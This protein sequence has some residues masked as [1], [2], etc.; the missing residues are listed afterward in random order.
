MS[1]IIHTLKTRYVL[2]DAYTSTQNKITASTQ[3]FSQAQGKGTAALQLF[4]GNISQAGQAMGM[5]APQAMALQ[6]AV[7]FVTKAIEVAIKTA[8][9][10]TIAFG[11]FSLYASHQAADFEAL[12][13]GIKAYTHDAKE[14]ADAQ[15]KFIEVAKLPGLGIKES[16]AGAAQLMSVGFDPTLAARTMTEFGN[17]LALVGKG[18][19]DLDGVI[20]ALTQIVSK[21]KVSAEEILQIAE[22]VPQIRELMARAFGTAN[23]ETLQQMNISVEEFI[24]K[25]VDMAEKTIPRM[26][27]GMK[28]SWE[29]MTDSIDKGIIV[30]G[31]A[32]NQY[33]GPGLDFLGDWL[34]MVAESGQLQTFVDGLMEAVG[35][36]DNLKENF[37]HLA[38]VTTS[39]FEQFGRQITVWIAEIK[40]FVIGLKNV[41][42]FF[43]K[44]YNMNPLNPIKLPDID[45]KDFNK[46]LDQWTGGLI[47]PDGFFNRV[48]EG[49]AEWEDRFKA[50]TKHKDKEKKDPAKGGFRP[51]FLDL[52]KG[53]QGAATGT[54]LG[55]IEEHTKQTAMNTRLA[56][57]QKHILGGGDL[58]R[59]GP[60]PYEIGAGGRPGSV[61]VRVHG[62]NEIEQFIAI[63]FT[64]MLQELT[65]Q[66][67]QFQ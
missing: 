49:T 58:G 65:R 54:A 13:M 23:T 8:V 2:D 25:I 52:F 11:A 24:T 46:R 32:I 62:G 57:I 17:A 66:G 43:A 26:T 61:N 56:N 12:Q 19:A 33:L 53:T 22:R 34:T 31:T 51:E 36:T 63:G 21:G 38:A 41:Y 7:Q 50:W 55:N 29:N 27:S 40:G 10:G 39:F 15:R 60:M 42:E 20:M 3:K 16:M 5:A 30:F 45:D 37:I 64:N 14:A 1:S 9:A 48:G 59:V 67:Y 47:N 35:G 44:L 6:T 4:S 28:N 18:K